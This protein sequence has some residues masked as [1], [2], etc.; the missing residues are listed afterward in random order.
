MKKQHR[1]NNATKSWVILRYVDLYIYI[2]IYIYI[3]INNKKC[4]Y[5]FI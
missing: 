5:I 4:I 3:F 1:E 2:Y